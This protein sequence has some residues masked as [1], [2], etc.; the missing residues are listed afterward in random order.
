MRR[1]LLSLSVLVLAAPGLAAAAPRAPIPVSP[2]NGA[3]TRFLPALGWKAVSG[4]DH[5]VYQLAADAGFNSPVLVSGAS[6]LETYNTWA[7]FKTAVPNGKYYWHVRAVDRAGKVSPWSSARM[8]SKTWQGD[9]EVVSPGDGATIQF[10]TNPTVKWQP[11]A[12][13][14]KYE[15]T[16][17]SVSDLSTLDGKP[18]KAV[19]TDASQFTV[20]GGLSAGSTYFWTVTPIDG[21]GNRGTPPSEPWRFTWRWTSTTHVTFEDLAP[22]ADVVDPRFSWDPIPNAARY[23]VEINSDAGFAAGSK[24]CCTAATVATVLSPATVLPNNRYYWRVRGIDADGNFGVWNSW[25]NPTAH[26]AFFRKTFDTRDPGDFN[27]SIQNLRMADNVSDS[28]NDFDGNPLNGY[29]T[30]VPIVTWDPVLGA[31]GYEI[32]VRSFNGGGCSALLMDVTAGT[33]AWAPMGPNPDVEPWPNHGRSLATDGAQLAPDT[34]YCVRV[35][36]YTDRAF[37]QNHVL[38]D[39]VGDWSY[40]DNGA[41]AGVVTSSKV[42]FQFIGYPDDTSCTVTQPPPTCSVDPLQ[43]GDYL[44]PQQGSS[45][46]QTPYFTWNPTPRAQGYFV[47]VSR[48]ANFTTV[49][50]YAWVRGPAY[51]PRFGGNATTYQDETTAYY[52]AVLPSAYPDGTNPL[53]DPLLA[54]ASSFEKEAAPPVLAGPTGGADVA[55][56]PTFSWSLAHW[57]RTYT[58]QV[59]TDPLFSDVV[60]T[61]ETTSSSYTPETSYPAEES[62]YW[63]V[64]S[65]DWNDIALSWSPSAVFRLTRTAPVVSP[66]NVAASE[67]VPTWEWASVQG[68]VSYDV[69]VQYPNGTKK[70]YKGYRT[71]AFT[72]LKLDGIGIWHWKVRANFPTRS[73]F[74]TIQGSWS[75][76]AEFRNSMSAPKNVRTPSGGSGA[77]FAWDPKV[78]AA[79]YQV[80]VSTQQ[81]FSGSTVEKTQVDSP[82]YAPLIKNGG[83]KKGGTMYWRVAAVDDSGN[84]GEMT[85]ALGFKL[86]LA[87]KVQTSGLLLKGKTGKLTITVTDGSRAP[88]RGAKV[89]ITGAGLRTKTVTTRSSGK[90]AALR[91]RPKKRETITIT[92]SR[93]G[94]KTTTATLTVR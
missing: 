8:F 2:G 20:S 32:E 57:A 21:A 74:T 85:K 47:L 42:A 56:R 29:Q 45:V 50:D 84:I 78:G 90:T 72:P 93:S 67:L 79:H 16:V 46:D 23:D 12:G 30:H 26:E 1:A 63:R 11:V 43:T 68:A 3:T 14:A 92:V 65:N 87:L 40:L 7:S 17:A 64:R 83:Y 86:P 15:I 22:A 81:D 4:A 41:D 5:Y 69:E 91:L 59:A 31:S 53:L 27:P 71:T 24:F 54:N 39:V 38:H 88:V 66:T 77:V 18:A 10:P 73:A 61:I 28:G 70:L 94:Y 60:E 44:G 55:L 80:E 34:Y 35:R 33:N 89:T 52:W 51:A 37:D 6:V 76:I 49:I 75:A 36:A 19:E 82:T 9:T 62:L 48:D 58:V 13:A 25:T